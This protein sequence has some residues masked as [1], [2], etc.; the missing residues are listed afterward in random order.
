MKT[1]VSLF[2]TVTLSFLWITP[3]TG[4]DSAKI[5][6]I[7]LL[8]SGSGMRPVPGLNPN[9]RAFLQG[10]EEL[11]YVDGKNIRIERRSAD[12]QLNRLPE[13]A[14][15]L[16]RLNVAVIVP[17]GPTAVGPAM[18]ATTTIPIVMPNGGNPIERGFVKN[19][20][21]PGGNVT[22]LAGFAEGLNQKQMELLKETSSSVRRAVVLIPHKRR[23]S[24][25]EAY[26]EAAGALGIAVQTVDFY[27]PQNYDEALAKIVAMGP[28]ALITVQNTLTLRY[29]GQ[30]AE[31][32][33]KNRF[34]FMADDRRFPEAGALMS[35]GV[36]YLANWRR[37]AVFVDKILKGADPG[38]LPIEPPALKLVINL[39]TANKIGV[40]IP[41]EILLE[42]NEVIK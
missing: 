22:G 7:G 19:L 26:R 5:P 30:I 38:T 21:R 33:L 15:E 3:A 39:K 11:G 35:F 31:F 4:Q 25:G 41:P 17:S 29:A 16:V 32:A 40:T 8:I 10:L 23:Q 18:K 42:A 20:I 9:Y 14:A 12:G 27:N 13:L 36:N 2:L 1:V 24:T 28:D 34:L 6:R 37:A